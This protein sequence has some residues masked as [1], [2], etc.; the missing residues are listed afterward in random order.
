MKHKQKN[1]R[2][3]MSEI[4]CYLS[5]IGFSFI[6]FT[7]VLL[8][9]ENENEAP[10][11]QSLRAAPTLTGIEVSFKLDPRLTKSL[12]M[13]DRWVSP[14]IYTRIQEGKS[15]T[16]EIRAVGLDARGKP[17]NIKPEWIASDPEMLSITPREGNEVNILVQRDGES[18]LRVTSDRVS[19]T[20]GIKAVYKD[21][22]IYVEIAPQQDKQK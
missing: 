12:Y 13:G 21:N 19:K 8:A 6:A 16:V 17:H 3:L 4:L 18:T 10:N 22:T 9:G 15:I 2:A 14:P 7:E 1:F 11:Q 5:V 20:L